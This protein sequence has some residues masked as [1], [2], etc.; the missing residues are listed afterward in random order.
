MLT[1]TVQNLDSEVILRCSG[2]IVSG[3]E[4]AIL[5]AVAGHNGHNVT[6]DLEEVETID[7]TGLGLLISLQA[8]GFYLK[9]MNP[10]GPVRKQLQQLDSIFDVCESG[11]ADDRTDDDRTDNDQTDDNQTDEIAANDRS[12]AATPAH[13]RAQSWS[14]PH[15]EEPGLVTC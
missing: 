12:Q 7:A 5:C 3:Q 4:T 13:S 14:G 2:G 10:T 9:L 15:M 1:V 6:L 11:S 8:A